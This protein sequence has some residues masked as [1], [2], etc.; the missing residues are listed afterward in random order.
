MSEIILFQDKSGKLNLH[1]KL[2]NDT[3]WL[4]Q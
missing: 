4:M 1:V 2:D 3:V